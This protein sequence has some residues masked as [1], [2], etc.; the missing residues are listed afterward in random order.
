VKGQNDWEMFE[1]SQGPF[2]SS[3]SRSVSRRQLKKLAMDLR[4]VLRNE[5]ATRR[6]L[7]REVY[8]VPDELLDDVLRVRLSDLK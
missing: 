7:S 8:G 6:L 5:M 3:A 1:R 2:P 4:I